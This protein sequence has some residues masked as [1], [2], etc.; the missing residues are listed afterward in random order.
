MQIG[1][2]TENAYSS[3]DRLDQNL[4][5]YV[6]NRVDQIRV[7]T[8]TNNLG[9]MTSG[10]GDFGGTFSCRNCALSLRRNFFLLGYFFA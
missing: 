9:H 2:K 10:Y 7:Y 4:N 5:S 6:K 1:P 8:R 3:K